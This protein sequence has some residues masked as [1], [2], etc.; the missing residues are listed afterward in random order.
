[1]HVQHFRTHGGR[2]L[3]RGN[4]RNRAPRLSHAGRLEGPRP[5]RDACPGRARAAGEHQPRDARSTGAMT[6]LCTL[7][8]FA[9]AAQQ[10]ASI[11]G[12]V[13]DDRGT[14]LAGASVVVAGGPAPAVHPVLT[15]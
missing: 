11:T 9:L 4:G 15:M 12:R 6:L 14:P 13:V 3:R 10:A 2:V 1:A 8:A 7:I 5:A